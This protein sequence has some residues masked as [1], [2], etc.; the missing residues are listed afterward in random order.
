MVGSL[1]CTELGKAKIPTKPA[2]IEHL[3]AHRCGWVSSSSLL[4]H[5]L[6]SSTTF[7]SPLLVRLPGMDTP[8]VDMA[9]PNVGSSR[10]SQGRG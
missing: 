6:P 1:V 4:Q 5:L 2:R 9:Q 3:L 8:R 10:S 7:S